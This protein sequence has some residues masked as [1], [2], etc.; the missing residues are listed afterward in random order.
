LKQ[1]VE[2]FDFLPLSGDLPQLDKTTTLTING[3]PES[4]YDKKKEKPRAVKQYGLT[5]TGY[6]LDVYQEAGYMVHRISA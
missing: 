3:Y 2:E 1:D 5:K 4:K 6:I